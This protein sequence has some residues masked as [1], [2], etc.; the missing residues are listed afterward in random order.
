MYFAV[1]QLILWG[2]TGAWGSVQL[3]LSTHEPFSSAS[4]GS[5]GSVGTICLGLY[6]ILPLPLVYLSRRFPHLLRRA[7]WIAL[8]VNV[9]AMFGSS[10]ATNVGELIFLQGI[11]G[12]VSGAVMYIPALIWLQEWFIV[13]RGAAAGI[14]FAGQSGPFDEADPD[15]R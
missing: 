11:V 2:Y 15:E 10:F 9:I 6:Y 7:L 12:G 5:L 4:L 1:C 3:F 14:I 8:A 13:K